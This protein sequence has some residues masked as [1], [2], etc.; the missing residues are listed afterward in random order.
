MFITN[1]YQICLY[2]KI[3]KQVLKD[4]LTDNWFK[5]VF[6]YNSNFNFSLVESYDIKSKYHWGQQ[7]ILIINSQLKKFQFFPN[8]NILDLQYLAMAFNKSF[9]SNSNWKVSLYIF[10]VDDSYIKKQIESFINATY[11]QII[12]KS[13]QNN[14][15]NIF[16]FHLLN[17]NLNILIKNKKSYEEYNL[18]NYKNILIVNIYENI[19]NLQL[20]NNINE[21]I[22]L[23]ML[24]KI[25][26]SISVFNFYN[27]EKF[28]NIK[29]L[30]WRFQNAFIKKYNLTLELLDIDHC[31]LVNEYVNNNILLIS[32]LVS[33]P[34][35]NFP[36]ILIYTRYPLLL[37]KKYPIHFIFI[38]LN[39]KNNTHNYSW[40]KL[41]ISLFKNVVS[42][43]IK[44]IRDINKV[45]KSV[46]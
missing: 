46:I 45:I 20:E 39:N 10:S 4:Y 28:Y 5:L 30:L 16:K 6:N 22:K 18:V 37:N 3:F 29:T 2:S 14:P 42:S 1:N 44:S 24:K 19:W 43:N 15:D 26:Q 7:L 36:I 13:F 40:L 34:D 8:I 23:L 11:E 33:F 12:I 38:L 32:Q 9:I 35:Y 25:Q 41:W 31:I 27:H 17:Q 21:T